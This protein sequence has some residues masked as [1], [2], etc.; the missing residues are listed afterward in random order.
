MTTEVPVRWSNLHLPTDGLNEVRKETDEHG[1]YADY[2][3][4]DLAGLWKKVSAS[5]RQASYQPTCSVIDDSRA[6]IR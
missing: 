2:S 4:G 3:G 6:V 5:F 1:Y